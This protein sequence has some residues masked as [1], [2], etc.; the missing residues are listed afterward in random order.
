MKERTLDIGEICIA[1]AFK[2]DFYSCTKGRNTE[3]F[4]FVAVR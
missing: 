1:M 4:T 3:V 2:K